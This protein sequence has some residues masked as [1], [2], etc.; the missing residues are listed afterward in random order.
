MGHFAA[1]CR[2]RG[3][4]GHPSLCEILRLAMHSSP[5]RH[6]LRPFTR[7]T[8]R[9]TRRIS[10]AVSLAILD[11]C[12]NRVSLEL[13]VARGQLEEAENHNRANGPYARHEVASRI[14]DLR[15]SVAGLEEELAYLDARADML[16]DA[17][18][19]VAGEEDGLADGDTNTCP[20]AAAELAA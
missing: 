7:L 14:V 3:R 11:H 16:R 6:P 20:C 9:I 1:V 13:A 4:N 5:K 19:D 17:D 10:R 15:K 12:R 18:A 2:T 8:R